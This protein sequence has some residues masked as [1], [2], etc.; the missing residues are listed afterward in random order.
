MQSREQSARRGAGYARR[1]RG[2]SGWR[3]ETRHARVDAK[4]LRA[5][6]WGRGADA[7]SSASLYSHASREGRVGTGWRL[8]FCRVGG[9][10]D[11]GEKWNRSRRTCRMKGVASGSGERKSEMEKMDVG[12]ELRKDYLCDDEQKEHRRQTD[13]ERRRRHISK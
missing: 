11:A 2:C 13:G 9:E 8:A 6:A 1:S 12:E 10:T 5:A 3:R 4:S 7:F